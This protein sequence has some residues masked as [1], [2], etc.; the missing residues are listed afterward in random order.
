MFSFNSKIPNNNM[1]IDDGMKIIKNNILVISLSKNKVNEIIVIIVI[2][3]TYLL[4]FDIFAPC[5]Q[6][7]FTFG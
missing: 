6:N 2:K 4:S 3:L 7:I 5:I 1:K